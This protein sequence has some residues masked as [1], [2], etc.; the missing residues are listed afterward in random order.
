MKSSGVQ[1]EAPRPFDLFEEDLRQLGETRV[2]DFSAGQLI[3]QPG[4]DTEGIFFVLHGMARISNYS[5]GTKELTK[6]F[7][8]KGDM[9]GELASILRAKR[10]DYAHAM[11][12]TTI[13]VVPVDQL[14]LLMRTNTAFNLKLMKYISNKLLILE[15]RLE[16]I[17][18]KDSK[19][20]IHEY[21]RELIREKGVRIGY[22]VLIRH[23]PTHQEI[24]NETATSRQTVTTVLN[25]LRNQNIISVDRKRLLI[26]EP[27]QI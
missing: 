20:R 8:K 10:R 22:E 21:M 6:A 23:F 17:V 16:N 13:M 25:N 2:I 4:D 7:F 3:Y 11:E 9:F 26:R 14:H 24:A 19:T 1:S 5:K 27:D 15:E 18:F 12:D